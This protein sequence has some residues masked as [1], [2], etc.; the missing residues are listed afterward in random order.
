MNSRKTGEKAGA[1]FES[2]DAG[3]RLKVRPEKDE[4]LK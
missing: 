2:Q 1:G 4:K 3:I